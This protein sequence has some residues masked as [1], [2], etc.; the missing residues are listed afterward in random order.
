MSNI[1]NTWPPEVFNCVNSWFDSLKDPNSGNLLGKDCVQFLIKSGLPTMTLRE[2][3]SVTEQMNGCAAPGSLSREGFYIC[4]RIVSILCNTNYQEGTLPTVELLNSTRNQVFDMPNMGVMP[5]PSIEIS[6]V[7]STAATTT[8]T[9]TLELNNNT[10]DN[11]NNKI[12]N[13]TENDDDDEDDDFGEFTDVTDTN[14]DDNAT[15]SSSLSIS[16]Q[17]TTSVP[18]TIGVTGMQKDAS[19]NSPM[20]SNVNMGMNDIVSNVNNRMSMNIDTSTAMGSPMGSPGMT[21]TSPPAFEDRLAAFEVFDLMVEE[22]NLKKQQEELENEDWDDFAEANVDES[23]QGEGEIEIEGGVE[24]E[25]KGETEAGVVSDIQNESTL[26]AMAVESPTDPQ[27][28]VS[29]NTNQ[30]DF[31]DLYIDEAGESSGTVTKSEEKIND[32][33]VV[34]VNVSGQKEVQIESNVDIV[35]DNIVDENGGADKDATDDDDFEDFGDF[36]E[37]PSECLTTKDKDVAPS[38][39]VDVPPSMMDT[40]TVSTESFGLHN[41]DDLDIDLG[42]FTET[43]IELEEETIVEV[44]EKEEGKEERE[45]EVEREQVMQMSI[46]HEHQEKTLD[47]N[48]LMKQN[49]EEDEDKVAVVLSTAIAAE[50]DIDAEVEVDIEIDK[51]VAN[52]GANKEGNTVNDTQE[53]LE[54]DD[55]EEWDD[56]TSGVDTETETNVE[57]EEVL[58]SSAP[59]SNTGEIDISPLPDP[60][61]D[62]KPCHSLA[63]TTF[64]TSTTSITSKTTPTLT[65]VMFLE[66]IKS[67]YQR[68]KYAEALVCCQQLAKGENS[69]T[70][71]DNESW[72]GIYS[73]EMEIA[74]DPLSAM[75]EDSFEDMLSLLGAVSVE[76]E[77]SASQFRQMQIPATR[78]SVITIEQLLEQVDVRESDIDLAVVAAAIEC[79]LRVLVLAKCSLR[80]RIAV[81]TTHIN[82]PSVWQK[83]LLESTQI[84]Q[85]LERACNEFNALPVTDQE[86]VKNDDR[87]IEFQSNAQSIVEVTLLL[88]SSMTDANIKHDATIDIRELEAMASRVMLGTCRQQR[89]VSDIADRAVDCITK[90]TRA[91]MVNDV[92]YRQRNSFN[93]G[94]IGG[95][96]S[97]SLNGMGGMSPFTDISS[98]PIADGDY[99][100]RDSSCSMSTTGIVMALQPPRLCNLSLQPLG[101]SSSVVISCISTVEQ[102]YHA[103]QSDSGGDLP[104]V[105]G[106]ISY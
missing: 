104:Q 69:R 79:E 39:V 33:D 60:D 47:L 13:V 5:I 22:D 38:S 8:T 93:L 96:S 82:L 2:V 15:S 102:F 61:L 83:L 11:Q 19:L 95:G 3:W 20:N 53:P 106:F 97:D 58:V 45:E 35:T 26:L 78:N 84:L 24:E 16:T 1:T 6:T 34:Q 81:C 27:D 65:D 25:E 18:T 12:N 103:T 94:G 57:N 63:S 77:A 29:T 41:L 73:I 32:P 42:N 71:E 51:I 55:D 88:I 98:T 44:K 76:G 7:Q 43:V 86:L 31:Q 14:A 87:Y 75:P 90:C 40:R 68:N 92:H 91:V 52:I 4:M 28:F 99:Q 64:T 17:D 54:D 74:A 56:F 85:E 21:V 80:M 37:A 10:E 50:G 70:H 49:E 23:G 100:Y 101:V 48:T 62:V 59:S 9:T 89:C 46:E 67:L 72:E 30:T 66:L 36:S 105:T